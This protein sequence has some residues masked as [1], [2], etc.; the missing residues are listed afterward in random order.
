MGAQYRI[1]LHTVRDLDDDRFG[2]LA[3]FPPLDPVDE[4]YV[5]EGRELGRG[6]DEE[7]AIALAERLAG[8]APDRWVNS[9]VAGEEYLDLVGPG[10]EGRQRRDAAWPIRRSD[11]C[12]RRS[13][14]AGRAG[15][16]CA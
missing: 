1:S 15:I 2:D 4:E 3:E 5:G 16:G 9:A 10:E 13:R 14:R 12:G 11:P 7:E 8:A 6:A